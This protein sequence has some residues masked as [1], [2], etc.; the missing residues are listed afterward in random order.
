MSKICI[1][2][3]KFDSKNTCDVLYHGDIIISSNAQENYMIDHIMHE[4]YVFKNCEEYTHIK[5]LLKLSK[6]F[7]IRNNI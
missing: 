3:G 4:L 2:E 7:M 6:F 5:K 1:G